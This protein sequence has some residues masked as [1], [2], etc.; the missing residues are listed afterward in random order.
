MEGLLD[1]GADRAEL[2][3]TIVPVYG[4]NRLLGIIPLLGDIV[5]GGEGQGIFSATYR[6]DGKL[7]DPNISVN[8]LAVLAPG[9]LRNLFF[10]DHDPGVKKDPWVYEYP[11]VG[12]RAG[13]RW[14]CWAR[15]NNG[16]ATNPP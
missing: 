15:P 10:L 14:S 7:S 4:L 9:F 12:L 2:Q 1:V 16:E 3:G 6:I 5:T 11:R 8:P 13:W